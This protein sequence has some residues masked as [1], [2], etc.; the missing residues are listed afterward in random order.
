MTR[1]DWLSW[2]DGRVKLWPHWSLRALRAPRT[3]GAFERLSVSGC[4]P[5]LCFPPRGV[6][7]HH[8]LSL[9]LLLKETITGIKPCNRIIT[10]HNNIIGLNAITM[11]FNVFVS[12]T[13]WNTVLLE[14]EKK[15]GGAERKFV[16]SS[17]TEYANATR[18]T[19]YL[20]YPI[21]LILSLLTIILVGVS[22]KKIW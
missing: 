12:K 14:K 3:W 4:C 17:H 18:I 13:D 20:M 5:R 8:L 11:P 2:F 16:Q 1:R 22:P 15:K 10:S 7:P 19:N 21:F 6:K 9:S